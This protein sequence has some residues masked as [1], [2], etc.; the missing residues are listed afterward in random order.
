V[1]LIITIYAVVADYCG[2]GLKDERI[3]AGSITASSSWNAFHGPAQARLDYTGNSG[4]WSSRA[5]M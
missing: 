5:S 4:S 1:H 2:V 3:P